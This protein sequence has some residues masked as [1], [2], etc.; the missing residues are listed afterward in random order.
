MIGNNFFIYT[1]LKVATPYTDGSGQ[2]SVHLL[3]EEEQQTQDLKARLVT[4]G[5]SGNVKL[6]VNSVI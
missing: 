2:E 6:Q 3:L 5:L 1:V 4:T